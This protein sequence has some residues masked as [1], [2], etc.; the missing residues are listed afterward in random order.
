MTEAQRQERIAAGYLW[1]DT[2]EYI[3]HQAR[4]RDLMYEFNHSK[5]ER[6]PGPLLASTQVA[7]LFFT[8]CICLLLFRYGWFII[9]RDERQEWH[10]EY[11]GMMR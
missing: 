4:V 7:G 11:A 6:H 2:E 3:A 9:V 1:T 10:P 8:R 5:T